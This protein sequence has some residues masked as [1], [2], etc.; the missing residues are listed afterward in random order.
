V[1]GTQQA[2]NGAPVS[3]VRIAGGP[4]GMAESA[5]APKLCVPAFPPVCSEQR[6]SRG[7]CACHLQGASNML[8]INDLQCYA[9]RC[10][11]GKLANHEKI[12]A[13]KQSDRFGWLLF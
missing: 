7:Q 10:T 6:R 11:G 13:E 3:G 4:A 12:A 9:R 8:S 5:E 2:A 1:F